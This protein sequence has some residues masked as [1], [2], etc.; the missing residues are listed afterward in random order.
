MSS[1]YGTKEGWKF[2]GVIAAFVLVGFFIFSGFDIPTLGL[3][4]FMLIG[5]LGS[6]IIPFWLVKNVLKMDME[7]APAKIIFW[8]LMLILF[9]LTLTYAKS[10]VPEAF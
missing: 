5:S 1:D 3:G 8:V 6:M 10:E 4:V 9:I 7:E 2:F